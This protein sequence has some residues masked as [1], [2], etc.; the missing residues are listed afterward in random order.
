MNSICRLVA[1]VLLAGVASAAVADSSASATLTSVKLTLV[2]LDPADGVTPWIIFQDSQ[3]P[4]R[5]HASVW[6]YGVLVDESLPTLTTAFTSF[7]MQAS[8]AGMQA[9]GFFMADATGMGGINSAQST[10]AFG[11][12]RNA[13][14]RTSGAQNPFRISDKTLVFVTA[15]STLNAEVT[16][17]WSGNQEHEVEMAS[18]E[19]FIGLSGPA[20]GGVGTGTQSSSAPHEIRIRSE[21]AW[22]PAIGQYDFSPASRSGSAVLSASF[23]NLS[24]SEMTGSIWVS[25][26][27]WSIIPVPEPASAWLMLVGLLGTGAVLRYRRR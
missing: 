11:E 2:D 19:N 16:E 24:G 1:G 20:A 14:V 27:A 5:G 6:L 17:T 10:A 7:S 26:S 13:L 3:Y 15:T 21:A 4:Y 8:S 12:Y 22:N 25:S 23:V 9:S 18:A